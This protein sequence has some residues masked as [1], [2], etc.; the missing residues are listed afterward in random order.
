MVESI[1]LGGLIQTHG[2]TNVHLELIW[3]LSAYFG[4]KIERRRDSETEKVDR[5]KKKCWH[6]ALIYGLKSCLQPQSFTSKI[7][8]WN[9][10]LLM[11]ACCCVGAHTW[12]SI[13]VCLCVFKCMLAVGLLIC[14]GECVLKFKVGFLSRPFPLADRAPCR[15]A[16]TL[17]T[18]CSLIH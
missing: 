10:L 7:P 14:K 15:S 8:Y 9:F 5:E 6:S 16:C 12:V 11:C 4:L 17:Q 2:S 3:I 1:E 18:L 13:S